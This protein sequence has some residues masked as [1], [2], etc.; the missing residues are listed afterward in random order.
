MIAC[1]PVH[2]IFCIGTKTGCLELWRTESMKQVCSIKVESLKQ[3]GE[4]VIT[5]MVFT[6]DWLIVG[7]ENGIVRFYALKTNSEDLEQLQMFKSPYGHSI[8][9]L[10]Q[11]KTGYVAGMDSNNCTFLWRYYHRDFNLNKPEEWLLIGRNQAHNKRITDICF[12]N[13]E[14]SRLFSVGKDG[15]IQ[16]YDIENA[17]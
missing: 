10:I 14:N 15:I 16:E 8:E 6:D 11:T 2:D 7:F 1:H 4:E 9:K 13:E 12:S 5:S 3:D 17:P